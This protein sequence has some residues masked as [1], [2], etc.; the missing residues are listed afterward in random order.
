MGKRHFEGWYFKHQKGPD[1]AAFI[2]GR[3]DSGAFIQMVTPAG[4]RQ[5]PV[6]A[7]TVHRGLIQADK[8]R[9]SPGGCHIDLPGVRGD[10]DYGPMVK[11]SSDIMGPFRF[12]PMECRH[13]ILSMG[14]SLRGRVTIDGETHCFDGGTGY[15]ESDAGRS[16]PREYL[17]VQCN[18]FPE[19]WAITAAAAHIPGLPV[20]GCICAILYGG[21][22]Y[23]L[24]TYRGARIRSWEQGRLCL[25]QGPYLLD[26]QAAPTQ[27]HRLASPVNGQM[28]A[29]IHE[30]CC[31]PIRARLWKNGKEIFDL[32]SQEAAWEFVKKGKG[33]G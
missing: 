9:F 33:N 17:W 15:I 16:F 24:A 26:I 11:L 28:T 3:A 18:S 21:R 29:A 7:L 8:C 4:S 22:E 27:G 32:S 19:K 2:P 14:H 10:L 31:V 13:G 12:L 1:M 30:S 23:R 5:F 6:E 20:P 25:T